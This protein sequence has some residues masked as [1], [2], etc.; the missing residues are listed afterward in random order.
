MQCVN[1]ALMG[2]GTAVTTAWTTFIGPL[3]KTAQVSNLSDPYNPPK[4]PHE[5]AAKH[6]I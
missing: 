1:C 6:K 5:A 2:G 4:Q 3:S